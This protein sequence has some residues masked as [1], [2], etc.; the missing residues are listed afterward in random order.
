VEDRRSLSVNY[1]IF[2]IQ[3][4]ILTDTKFLEYRENGSTT[5]LYKE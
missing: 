3:L 4:G 5:K 1:A 2:L